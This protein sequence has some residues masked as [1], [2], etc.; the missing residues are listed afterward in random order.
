MK[1]EETSYKV[2]CKECGTLGYGYMITIGGESED[3]W[4]D[5]VTLCKKCL[6]KLLKEIIER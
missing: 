6:L 2:F 3:E 5:T 4:P 1:L